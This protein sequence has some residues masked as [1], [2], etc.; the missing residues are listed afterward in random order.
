MVRWVDVR[1]AHGRG[2][3][4][5]MWAIAQADALVFPEQETVGGNVGYRLGSG[6]HDDLSAPQTASFSKSGYVYRCSCV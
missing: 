6:G 3:N 5:A 2:G 1:Q 4:A